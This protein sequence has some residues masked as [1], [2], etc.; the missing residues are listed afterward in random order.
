MKV[1]LLTLFAFGLVYAAD[2]P[3]PSSKR[4]IVVNLI[5]DGKK[6]LP[7]FATFVKGEHSFKVIDIHGNWELELPRAGHDISK[8]LDWILAN[9]NWPKLTPA[10]K[11]RL[12]EESRY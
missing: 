12:L 5:P 9:Q 3:K 2:K 7:A 10:Q 1:T 8:G 4:H 6:E 11:E